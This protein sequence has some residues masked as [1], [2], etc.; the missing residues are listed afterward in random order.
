MVSSN[1]VDTVNDPSR[2]LKYLYDPSKD[3]DA[4]PSSVTAH[5]SKIFDSP[6]ALD[7]VRAPRPHHR[8]FVLSHPQ[9]IHRYPF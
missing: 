2:A 4:F 9:H 8:T 3:I 5:F 1:L 7:E 6:K